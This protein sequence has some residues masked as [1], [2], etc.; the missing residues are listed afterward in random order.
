MFFENCRIPPTINQE[1]KLDRMNLLFKNYETHLFYSVM[2][3]DLLFKIIKFLDSNKLF[4]YYSLHE[5]FVTTI[6]TLKGK[7]KCFEEALIVKNFINIPYRY[8]THYGN[9]DRKTKFFYI[10]G[11]KNIN[12]EL[13]EKISK[14]FNID[15][16]VKEMNEIDILIKNNLGIKKEY[17]FFKKIFFKIKIFY[18]STFLIKNLN[19][20][21]YKK[22][23]KGKR[24]M[25]NENYLKSIGLEYL[26]KNSIKF[27][28]KKNEEDFKNYV[29]F[30]TKT[31][32]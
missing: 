22:Y 28:N 31:V 14:F 15:I 3:K 18:S 32:E 16:S 12:L 10:L 4:K 25:T 24:I 6:L 29:N 19:L 27:K 30:F 20:L 1:N 13:L 2:K 7:V 26:Q 9:P 11:K 21:R 8:D 23:L 5:L 17:S